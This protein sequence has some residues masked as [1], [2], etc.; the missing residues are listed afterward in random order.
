MRLFDDDRVNG[1]EGCSIA[2]L[3]ERQSGSAER[4]LFVEGFNGNKVLLRPNFIRLRVCRLRVQRKRRHSFTFAS[5][6][7]Q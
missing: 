3:R 4:L 1:R 2:L 7:D 6:P 5:D